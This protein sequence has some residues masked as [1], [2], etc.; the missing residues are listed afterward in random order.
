MRTLP[1]SIA[2]SREIRP[3]FQ[4]G[5][6]ASIFAV[7]K[8]SH[9]V[10]NDN[11]VA[12][13][14]DEPENEATAA[15]ALTASSSQVPTSAEAGHDVLGLGPAV[16]PDNQI[17]KLM[18]GLYG[19]QQL[20]EMAPANPIIC[21]LVDTL[22]KKL[23]A[24]REYMKVTE[25]AQAPHHESDMGSE[26]HEPL[27]TGHAQEDRTEPSRDLVPVTTNGMRTSKVELVERPSLKQLGITGGLADSIH[28]KIG[29]RF[30]HDEDSEPSVPDLPRI[31]PHN[32]PGRWKTAS[33][34]RSTSIS[35]ADASSMETKTSRATLSVARC[36]SFAVLFSALEGLRVLQATALGSN[37]Y[38]VR[39]KSGNIAA[40][41]CVQLEAFNQKAKQKLNMTWDDRTDTLPILSEECSKQGGEWLVRQVENIVGVLKHLPG[42]VEG[43]IRSV[44]C[45]VETTWIVK[46]KS[47]TTAAG[48]MAM[49]PKK[50]LQASKDHSGQ[51]TG[52]PRVMMF[53][54]DQLKKRVPGK[55]EEQE[56]RP[57]T[58]KKITTKI[59]VSEVHV[60]AN[61][62]EQIIDGLEATLDL[63]EKVKPDASS[64]E[65]PAKP[66]TTNGSPAVSTTYLLSVLHANRIQLISKILP[67]KSSVSAS[68]TNASDIENPGS[69]KADSLTF[70][71]QIL[72]GQSRWATTHAQPE[73]RKENG[74]TVPPKAQESNGEHIPP[75]N[76]LNQRYMKHSLPL[77]LIEQQAK[78]SSDDRE[79]MC[80]DQI[81]S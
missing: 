46:F 42:T 31:G 69:S 35:E 58:S 61:D 47:S 55:V 20:L 45:P 56:Q 30:A 23:Q 80:V 62:V 68:K 49:L 59:A 44:Q 22:Q 71:F 24:T 33:S 25:H 53:G 19:L 4:D 3:V 50:W 79:A 32:L 1:L 10:M 36:T 60:T 26:R 70:S 57:D 67:I 78:N 48:A 13:S 38:L 81:E 39:F 73:T 15:K 75:S 14:T 65:M 2:Q 7:Q 12:M 52:C 74:A 21:E 66:T 77:W 43:G 64:Q 29:T 8:P 27:Q 9:D 34:A 41:A 76:K 54:Q 72:G 51:A 11:D 18:Q 63:E 17:R 5:T 37:K 16:D 40:K 6:D 28:R